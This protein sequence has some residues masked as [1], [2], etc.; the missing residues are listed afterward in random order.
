[1]SI[2]FDIRTTVYTIGSSLSI[3]KRCL[4]SSAQT[5]LDIIRKNDWNKN[6]FLKAT[7]AYTEPEKGFLGSVLPDGKP[8][9]CDSVLDIVANEHVVVVDTKFV[10]DG[11]VIDLPTIVKAYPHWVSFNHMHSKYIPTFT[12]IDIAALRGVQRIDLDFTIAKKSF[13]RIKVPG[14]GTAVKVPKPEPKRSKRRIKT[15]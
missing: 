9:P 15:R 3:P 5:I 1:M 11:G 6:S 7:I 12:N 13:R 4:T 8:L 14:L 2:E 10:T